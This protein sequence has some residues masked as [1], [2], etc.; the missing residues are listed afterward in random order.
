MNDDDPHTSWETRYG[1]A[2]VWSGKVNEPLRAWGEGHPPGNGD[3]ALDLACGEGGD[4]LWLAQQGWQVTGVDFASAAITRA[5]ESASERGL[6]VTWITAD[7][8]TWAPNAPFRLVSLSFFH[9]HRDVR[10]AVWRVAADAV[11]ES[12]T[13]LITAHAP[14][15]DPTAPGPSADTRFD[16][17][18]IVHCIGEGWAVTYREVRR[19]AI[20]RHA[21]HTVTDMVVELSRL[22]APISTEFR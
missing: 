12:G 20:G 17:S 9:E 1:A 21:G 19:R 3:H 15:A 4:A 8:T 10:H 7:L 18:E 5:A 6:T 14:D 11:A 22:A 2:P 13:L 16:L